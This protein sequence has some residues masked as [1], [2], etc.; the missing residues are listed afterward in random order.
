MYP[1]QAERLTEILDRNGL[2]A[3]IATREPNV[4]YITG[5]RGLNHTVFETPQYAVFSRRGTGLVVTNVEIASIV[6][7]R[8]DADHVACFGGFQSAYD[9]R[10]GGD[11]KRI[12]DLMDSRAP[13]AADALASVLDGLGVRQ[14]TVGLDEG[15][16]TPAG[17]QRIVARLAGLTVVPAAGHFLVAR[18]MKG[19]W[20][21]EHLERGVHLV[22]E[23]LNEVIEKFEPGMTEREAVRLYQSEVVKRGAD[24]VPALIATGAR[25][26]IPLPLPSDRALRARDIV[27]FDV[28]CVVGG[29]HATIARTAVA[30]EPDARLA[31]AYRAIQ[32]GLEAAVAAVRPGVPASRI[33]AVAVDATH[34]AGLVTFTASHSGHAIG[35]ESYE[36]P[37]LTR[38][39]ETPLE[40]GEILRIELRH[41]EM[42]W[43]GLHVKETVLVTT[44]G[45][46][47]LNRSS[48]SLI[49][50]D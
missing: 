15:R 21:I 47:L 9:E 17:W 34:G 44:A 39:V 5:F 14:G 2:E 28:G 19:P 8:I 20:E 3:M 7:D 41:F 31:S 10:P 27:R 4:A 35:L 40:A 32:T 50:L 12:R 46:R 22:E 11:V 45:A 23:A 48:R 43:A 16:V 29:Y 42:G 38:G 36:R 25:T 37:K 1:H 49:V 6:A 30:G 18:R 24:P 13:S 26:W 33:H